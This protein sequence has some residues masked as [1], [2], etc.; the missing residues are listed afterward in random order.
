MPV[1]WSAGFQKRKSED[2]IQTIKIQLTMSRNKRKIV[3]VPYYRLKNF[4]VKNIIK[5]NSRVN[6]PN[7]IF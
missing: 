7:I 1:V 2:L 3:V 4:T 6:A 5:I